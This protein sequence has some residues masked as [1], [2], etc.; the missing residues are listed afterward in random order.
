LDAR[1]PVNKQ[2]G[3]ERPTC[4][5]PLDVSSGGTT[6]PAAFRVDGYGATTLEGLKKKLQQFLAGAAFRSCPQT[7]NP[8]DASSPGQREE[9][10]KELAGFLSER[11]MSIEPYLEE[12]CVL[13]GVGAVYWVRPSQSQMV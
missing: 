12:K 3:R 10:F 13:W 11:S 8:F 4:A 7:S 2:W 9:I 6:Y 5:I 1:E